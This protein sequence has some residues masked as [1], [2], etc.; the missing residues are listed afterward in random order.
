MIRNQQ[1]VDLDGGSEVNLEQRW[2]NYG[3]PRNSVSSVKASNK[4]TT[5]WK[6]PS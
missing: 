3:R 2:A 6:K 5:W 1:Y 4:F